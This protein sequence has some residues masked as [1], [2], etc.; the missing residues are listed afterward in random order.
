M[1]SVSG[2]ASSQLVCANWLNKL[3]IYP[4]NKVQSIQLSFIMASAIFV[5]V[6]SGAKGLLTSCIALR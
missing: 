1:Q 6:T 3:L 2:R 5:T 4:T